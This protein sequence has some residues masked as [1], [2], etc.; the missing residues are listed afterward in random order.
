L[1]YGLT[2]YSN[3]FT[4]LLRELANTI[5][6]HNQ[7]DRS[8]KR[9]AKQLFSFF[10]KDQNKVLD[11]GEIFIGMVLLFGGTEQEKIRVAFE[12]Y[13][14]SGDMLLQ[15]DELFHYFTCNFNMILHDT[16]R[17]DLENVKVKDIAYATAAKCFKECNQPIEG[18]AISL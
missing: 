18:G 13:D 1:Y 8:I 11:F 17:K 3:K 15:F 6:N 12:L 2:F 4:N 16:K 10:D 14:D 7:S 5:P 9:A